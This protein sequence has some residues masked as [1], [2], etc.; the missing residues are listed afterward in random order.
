MLA[1]GQHGDDGFGAAGRIAGGGSGNGAS[2]GELLHGRLRKI[3]NPE[4]MAR[5]DQI[6]GHWPAHIAEPDKADFCHPRLL[7]VLGKL[8]RR[9]QGIVKN[10]ARRPPAPYSAGR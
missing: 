2:S 7:G 4:L 9:G 5:L 1:R 6:G 10:A 8:G 3:E